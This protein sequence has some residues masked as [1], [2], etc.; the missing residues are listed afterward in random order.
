[1]PAPQ[2]RVQHDKS[3]AWRSILSLRD[4]V[5]KRRATLRYSVSNDDG[6]TWSKT[7]MLLPE[8]DI[9]A[10]YYPARTI[11]LDDEHVGTV[12]MNRKGV[13]F[14]KVRLDRIVK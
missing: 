6:Q 11:P 5:E 4:P 14:L 9:T 3:P 10:R 7:V 13:H 8:L 1:L 2:I 12:F